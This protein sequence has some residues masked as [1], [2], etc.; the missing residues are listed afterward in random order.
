MSSFSKKLMKNKKFAF[1]LVL[2]LCFSLVGTHLFG[3]LPK[4]GLES[5]DAYAAS[6]PVDDAIIY[7]SG[8]IELD[9]YDGSYDAGRTY[10]LYWSTNNAV[11]QADIRTL[12][13]IDLSLPA[14]TDINT[15]D[16][17][18]ITCLGEYPGLGVAAKELPDFGAPAAGWAG[19]D[20]SKEFYYIARGV[21]D[22]VDS[23]TYII[24][25][26]IKSFNKAQADAVAGFAL[27]TTQANLATEWEVS[28]KLPGTQVT[29]GAIYGSMAPVWES[30]NTRYSS[31]N[32]TDT[33]AGHYI[34]GP[35]WFIQTYSDGTPT[36]ITMMTAGGT[37]WQYNDGT[38]NTNFDEVN[39]ADWITTPGYTDRYD[40]FVHEFILAPQYGHE[41]TS[42]VYYNTVAAHDSLLTLLE[43][44]A[45]G[46]RFYGFKISGQTF[47]ASTGYSGSGTV[48][49]NSFVDMTSANVRN[50]INLNKTSD[51]DNVD[52]S[53]SI[54][55]RFDRTG[56]PQRGYGEYTGGG[57]IPT[58][59]ITTS[60]VDLATNS[61]AGSLAGNAQIE[62][63]V[64]ME[65]LVP[66]AQYRI[67]TTVIDKDSGAVII[68]T[69]T[70]TTARGSIFTAAA[71]T[72]THTVTIPFGSTVNYFDR[73]LVVC[74]V[75][76]QLDHP[77]GVTEVARH[78]NASDEAQ[79]IHYSDL[80]TVL[81]ETGTSA[82]TV[83]SDASVDLT[84]TISLTNLVS[85]VEYYYVSTICDAQDNVLDTESGSFTANAATKTLTVDHTVDLSTYAGET[86]HADFELYA[87][88]AHTVVLDSEEGSTVTD[89]QVG[90]ETVVVPI[91]ITTT[92]TYSDGTHVVPATATSA[93]VTDAV[94]MTGLDTNKTYTLETVIMDKNTGSAV[95]AIPAIYTVV[96]PTSSTTHTESV[97]ITFDATLVQGR[98][99]VV[100]EYLREG[101][102]VKT[103]A[104]VAT[105][106]DINDT[107]QTVTIT[108]MITPTI[109]TV[110][111]DSA[112]TNHTMTVATD[113]VIIDAVSY[114]NVSIG[115]QYTLTATVYDKTAGRMISGVTG[116][117]TFTPT[118]S[119]GTVNVNIN[120]DTTAYQG[121]TLVVY[122]SLKAGGV[123]LVSHNDPADTDQTVTVPVTPTLSTVAT[124]SA[125]NTHTLT[126]GPNSKIHEVVTYTNVQPNAAYSL[127]TT[128]WD[129]TTHKVVSEI[130]AIDTPFTSTSSGSGT[131][132]VD[133]NTASLPVTYYGH[134]LV[135]YEELYQ[136]STLIVEHKSET[137]TNQTVNVPQPT[138][139]TTAF[140][141]GSVASG[142]NYNPAGTRTQNLPIG[143]AVTINDDLIYT[144]LIANQQ[145]TIKSWAVD[146]SNGST[147]TPV[148]TTTFTPTN[149]SGTQTVV[150]APVNTTALAGHQL[151]VYEQIFIGDTLVVQHV[152]IG[153]A[154]Q[155]LTVVTPYIETDAV[156]A[157]NGTHTLNYAANAQIRDTIHFTNFAGGS[158]YTV[159]SSVY[160]KATGQRCTDIAEITT[161]M[162]VP[163][164]GNGDFT[165]TIPVN[166]TQHAGQ[167]LV[168]YE[169]IKDASGNIIAQHVDINDA[170]QS[171]TVATISTVLTAAD[172]RSKSLSINSAVGVVDTVTY[173][174]LV[175]GQTYVLTGQ[176]VDRETLLGVRPA[177]QTPATTTPA[178]PS[179]TE[180][181]LEVNGTNQQPANQQVTTQQ[182]QRNIPSDGVLATVTIEFTPSASSG[183]VQVPFTLDTTGLNG[184]H[185]VA[186]ETL[187]VKGGN[188]NSALATHKDLNDAN[189]TVVVKSSA[190][191]QTGVNNTVIPFV[192]AGSVL[193][194]SFLGFGA[195]TF[196]HLKRKKKVPV[197]VKDE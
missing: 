98:T 119:N 58:V 30:G 174:G 62:D 145:Y 157:T 40:A 140:Y 75:L 183:S 191:V 112:T 92:A 158:S 22:W 159:T 71:A 94:V 57:D 61:R 109:S 6:L 173:S 4:I 129:A 23:D 84:D 5:V 2:M 17:H 166:A 15:A 192:V 7:D 114:E 105:H 111:T 20:D 135:V 178:A 161:A 167:T 81:A 176:L 147:V 54:M 190:T 44:N 36:D 104:T 126:V 80:D 100:Y 74:E 31:W 9:A 108:S 18:S 130:T 169:I 150:I 101:N 46:F 37:F 179:S 21:V 143:T 103:G 35:Y 97:A 146:K 82:K 156:D 43:G 177:E 1:T 180:A 68:P 175:P 83:D 153:D 33:A 133:I 185:I 182:P 124:D 149:A 95:T 47:P 32:E 162:T 8:T 121:H 56:D 187:S 60:A 76:Y 136:G 86:V 186:Y 193:F 28:S 66:G 45:V 64:A 65:G 70:G 14:T 138:L 48:D 118:T 197:P 106:T 51:F 34:D 13:S 39:Y 19:D 122:E 79:T 29:E 148:V 164:T 137:D 41:G 116:T 24:D 120:I 172:L 142:N 144:G 96:H 141:N 125:T 77:S 170:R 160:N 134:A 25:W 151:V 67:D 168:V 87:D 55:A 99:F 117:K 38:G 155:T 78:W 127:R 3:L 163:A 123:E 52:G 196:F 10:D 115:T 53:V 152:D 91:T 90:V 50:I 184:H 88:A 102:N 42:D 181:T 89:Q 188:N 72:E 128:V 85:G 131:V 110:A 113:A 195:F 16:E 12:Y 194:A 132:T 26:E 189:Q 139:A 93:T 27:P 59:T 154:N 73:S 63:S 69:I 49:Y 165:V 171:V 11:S 107:E